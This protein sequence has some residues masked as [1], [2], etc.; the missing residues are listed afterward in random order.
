MQE[1]WEIQQHLSGSR[2]EWFLL[3]FY[4]T[5]GF[6]WLFHCPKQL[7]PLWAPIPASHYSSGGCLP[8][9]QLGLW[10][11]MR[12]YYVPWWARLISSK[13]LGS[14]YSNSYFSSFIQN[15]KLHLSSFHLASSFCCGNQPTQWCITSPPICP[16]SQVREAHSF[17]VA[18]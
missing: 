16:E 18:L 10:F 1:N 4:S 15:V 8:K 17:T 2:P 5:G 7:C 3:C 12:L 13:F 14:L 6:G 9:D 11:S